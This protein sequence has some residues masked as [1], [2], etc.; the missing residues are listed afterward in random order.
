MSEITECIKEGYNGKVIQVVAGYCTICLKGG[1]SETLH[2]PKKGKQEFWSD[3]F[4]DVYNYQALHSFMPKKPGAISHFKHPLL[5]ILRPG[6][7]CVDKSNC[8][9]TCM[10]CHSIIAPDQAFMK[11]TVN[12]PVPIVH[13]ECM[14]TCAYIPPCK[15]KQHKCKA[16]VPSIPD[17]IKG[18]PAPKC[19]V[20]EKMEAGKQSEPVLIKPMPPPPTKPAP[21]PSTQPIP[22][23]NA[24]PKAAPKHKPTKLDK[25]PERGRSKDLLSMFGVKR[26]IAEVEAEVL[27]SDSRMIVTPHPGKSSKRKFDFKG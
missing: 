11:P 21:V 23:P 22:Q 19:I 24:K 27:P 7:V 15:G 8:F 5:N 1:S 16:P 6:E 10:F 20:H 14:A 9:P 25:D 12:F 2:I 3:L 18:I 26:P 17:Y 13:A 4:A